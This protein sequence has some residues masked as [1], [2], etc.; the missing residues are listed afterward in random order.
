[1]EIEVQGGWIYVLGTTADYQRFKIGKST[2]PLKRFKD[3]RTA[4]P[5][6]AI[7]AAYFVPTSKGRLSA[8]E[9]AIHRQ[10]PERIRFHDDEEGEWFSGTPKMA[11]EWMECLF[12]DWFG[13]DAASV[14]MLDQ[15]RICK[16]YEEDLEAIFMRKKLGSDGLPF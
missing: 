4:D 16:A 15:D 12:A 9:T 14:Y 1:M 7:E 8:V 10:F 3:L 13:E 2:N 6:L 11:C 5:Y